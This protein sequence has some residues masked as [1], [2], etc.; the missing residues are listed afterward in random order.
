MSKEVEL[1]EE[2]TT[3]L[4]AWSEAKDAVEDIK[5]LVAKELSLRKQVMEVFFPTPKEGTNKLSLP[6]DWVLDFQYKLN[7]GIDE[8]ILPAVKDTLTGMDIDP[9]QYFVYDPKL[10]L[11]PYRALAEV[12][13][14]AC[15]V[16]ESALIIKPGSHT[17]AL[18]A[19]KVK[20]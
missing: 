9:D 6:G 1:T 16:L 11:K 13:K 10:L 14:E 5:P 12:N 2:Q 15:K 17:I 19:P 18:I 20:K 3:L 4:I 7:R 8:E